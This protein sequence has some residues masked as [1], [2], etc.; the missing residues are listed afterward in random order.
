MHTGDPE[1]VTES[2]Q[3]TFKFCCWSPNSKTTVLCGHWMRT[4]VCLSKTMCCSVELDVAANVFGHMQQLGEF[5]QQFHVHVIKLSNILL[6][7]MLQGMET[8]FSV[9]FVAVANAFAHIEISGFL[10]GC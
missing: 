6:D 7:Q 4:G 5:A 1:V 3:R 8:C 2:W 10:I 9:T